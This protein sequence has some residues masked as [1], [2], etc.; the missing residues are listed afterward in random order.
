[1]SGAQELLV[2]A[3]VPSRQTI[4]IRVGGD[5]LLRVEAVVIIGLVVV[6][7]RRAALCRLAGLSLQQACSAIHGLRRSLPH[8]FAALLRAQAPPVA[9]GLR[10]LLL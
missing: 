7:L 6:R 10:R 2:G 5:G 1:M 9:D 8:A 3:Q 4:P